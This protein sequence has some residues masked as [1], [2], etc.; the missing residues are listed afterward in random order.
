MDDLLDSGI[1]TGAEKEQYSA[2][3]RTALLTGEVPGLGVWE[4]DNKALIRYI[5]AELTEAFIY[6]S[7]HQEEGSRQSF[8]HSRMYSSKPRILTGSS[9][10]SMQNIRMR[11][12]TFPLS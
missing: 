11:S 3:I 10:W 2:L 5:H 8:L 12:C 6:I 1:L 9:H 7:E 4:G